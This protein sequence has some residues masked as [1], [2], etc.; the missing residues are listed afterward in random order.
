MKI[1]GQQQKQVEPPRALI[2]ALKSSARPVCISTLGINVRSTTWLHRTCNNT[3]VYLLLTIDLSAIRPPLLSVDIPIR[4]CL[5][6][7]YMQSIAPR[8]S[9]DL[10]K[11]S[12]SA[13][14][15]PQEKDNNGED[16]PKTIGKGR[17]LR[18]HNSGLVFCSKH[19]LNS[20][21]IQNS[22]FS[23]DWGAQNIY[24][25]A[26]YIFLIYSSTSHW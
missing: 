16:W 4:S 6:S 9:K 14:H 15:S 5:P 18:S 17:R 7:K 13:P 25:F 1:M 26:N 2:S 20:F 10:R 23:N 24:S 12:S 22:L 19:R 3:S 11:S 8:N 21:G